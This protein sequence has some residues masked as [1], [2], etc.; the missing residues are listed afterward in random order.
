MDVGENSSFLNL[1]MSSVTVQRTLQASRVAAE[2]LIGISMAK[3]TAA[4]V[5]VKLVVLCFF[6]L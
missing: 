6:C 4:V 3:G 2:G 5:E 1:C